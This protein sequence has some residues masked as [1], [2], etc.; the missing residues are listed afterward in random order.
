VG[1][2]QYLLEE[3]QKWTCT[4]CGGVISLHDRLCSECGRQI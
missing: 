4:Q 2:E 1:A 3:K